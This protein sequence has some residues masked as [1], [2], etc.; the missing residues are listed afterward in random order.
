MGLLDDPSCPPCRQRTCF[1][2]TTRR[3]T[4]AVA[5][6][7]KHES[8]FE[9]QVEDHLPR[10]VGLVWQDRVLAHACK[11]HKHVSADERMAKERSSAWRA[12]SRSAPRK[13]ELFCIGSFGGG[14]CPLW[15]RASMAD[16]SV[17]EF[18]LLAARA[19][20]EIPSSL[21]SGDARSR[22]G[23]TRFGRVWTGNSLAAAHS[24]PG[25]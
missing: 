4:S 11:T 8:S 24:W 16:R 19:S 6:N 3:L 18:P 5:G 12:W 22:Y 25:L 13:Q 9:G 10:D 15:H 21:E 23:K 14:G 17:R 7:S 20:P 2:I 1:C